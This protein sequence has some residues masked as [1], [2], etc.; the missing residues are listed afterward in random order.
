MT[1]AITVLC[2]DHVFWPKSFLP[3]ILAPFN[4][5]EVGCV[6]TQKR[7]RRTSPGFSMSGFWN[8]LGCLWLERH[9]FEIAATNT[10]DGGVF[11]V[12][13][14]TSAHRS[15]ILKDKAFQYSFLNEYIFFG[16][17]GPLNADDDNFITRWIV[18]HG[19]KIKIQYC[20][21]ACIETTLG[22]YPKY[23]SQ[24]MRWART[25]WRNRPAR[26][27]SKQLWQTQPWC[28]YAVYLTSLVNF[29]LFYDA[30]MVYALWKQLTDRSTTHIISPF[31]GILT[32]C[33]CIFCGKLIKPW[34]HFRRNPRDLRYLPGYILFGYFHSLVKLWALLTFWN[35]TWGS[36]PLNMS[37]DGDRAGEKQGEEGEEAGVDLAEGVIERD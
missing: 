32:L 20:E 18:D 6:G 14:R 15:A 29:A 17:V 35:I 10:I 24:C 12:S 9:N 1:T 21:D 30:A 5:E 26:L 31:A 11:A 19:W 16:L 13:G 27:L 2:D 4:D 23:L 22:E 34:P 8:V 33:L 25:S 36:R 7:V 3:S 28:I 37:T